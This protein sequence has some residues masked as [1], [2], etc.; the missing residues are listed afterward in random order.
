MAALVYRFAPVWVIGI[1]FLLLSTPERILAGFL[2]ALA[3]LGCRWAALGRPL[4]F[5]RINL[6][7]FVLLSMTALSF[8]VSPAPELAV[9]AAGKIVAGVMLFFVL[10]DQVHSRTDLWR[11]ASVLAVLGLLFAFATPVTVNWGGD[12]LFDWPAFYERAGPPLTHGINANIMAG[13]LAPIVPVACAL[14]LSGRRRERAIGAISFG[15]I[16]LILLLLQSRGALLALSTGIAVYLGLYRR[17]AFLLV[18]L[19]L[20]SVA[21]VY[22]LNPNLTVAGFVRSDKSSSVTELVRNRPEIW[23]ESGRWIAQS[24]VVGVGLG[25]YPVIAER[26]FP[27]ELKDVTLL[28]HA[29]NLFIQIALDTGVVGLVGFLAI[30]MVAIRSLWL[31]YRSRVERHLAIGM[32][33]A[34]VIIL[35]HGMVDVIVWGSRAGIVLWLMLAVA[36]TFDRIEMRPQSDN[37]HRDFVQD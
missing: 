28:S 36:V 2:G 1:A 4:P 30:L 9:T 19:M 24:P 16:M 10:V 18:P 17:W 37:S 21:A 26:T 8:G 35:T 3:L 27:Q 34:F 6:W 31:A 11:A 15:P 20:L 7:L 5:T 29:H 23:E 25:A 33:A 12:K 32:L 22:S 13:A 14:M